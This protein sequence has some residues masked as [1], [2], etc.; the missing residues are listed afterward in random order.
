MTLSELHTSTPAGPDAPII[1]T[2]KLTDIEVF[3]R[4]CK[5][6][7]IFQYPNDE[8]WHALRNVFLLRTMDTLYGIISMTRSERQL[9]R[10]NLEDLYITDVIQT[11]RGAAAGI[12]TQ[13]T[14][15]RY[16]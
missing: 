5:D 15:P 12:S 10:V 11:L 16:G 14:T 4:Y 1:T 8:A 7:R 6:S 2:W 13:C 9:P 3:E